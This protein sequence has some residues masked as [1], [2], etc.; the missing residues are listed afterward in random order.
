VSGFLNQLPIYQ[1]AEKTARGIYLVIHNGG[2][3]AR[4]TALQKE[5]AV[6]GVNAP[7]V[8]VVDGTVRVSASKAK[9]PD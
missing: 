1:K 5:A 2:S 9:T 7:H 6:A 3:E 8:L 4:L